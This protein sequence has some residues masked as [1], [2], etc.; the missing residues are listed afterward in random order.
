MET[1]MNA[2][3]IDEGLWASSMAPQGLLDR[4][5][6]DHGDRIEAGQRLAEVTIE[7]ARHE[8]V[9]PAAGFLVRSCMAGDLV[10]PGDVIGRVR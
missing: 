3:R 4:W 10:S 5:F 2:I 8:I 7:S 1:A 9:A 6:A